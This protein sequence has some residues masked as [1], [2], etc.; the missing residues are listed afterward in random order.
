MDVLTQHLELY[1]QLLAGRNTLL[2]S[3]DLPG[4]YGRV[5]QSLDQPLQVMRRR[6]AKGPLA[7]ARLRKMGQT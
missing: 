3:Q 6:A 4:R 5:V 7:G 2:H 1:D